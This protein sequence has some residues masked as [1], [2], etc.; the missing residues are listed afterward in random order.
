[1]VHGNNIEGW[2]ED[3]ASIGESLKPLLNV[4][5]Q[6]YTGVQ[7]YTQV[8][9]QRQQA[10]ATASQLEQI[11]KIEAAQP[12]VFSPMSLLT[13]YWYIPIILS[14]VGISYYVYTQRR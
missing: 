7:Q 12:V 5:S 11:K 10:Q 13:E 1:M 14:I 6:V 4:G 9:Q 8:K 2:F 3:I